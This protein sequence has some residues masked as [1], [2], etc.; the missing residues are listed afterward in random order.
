MPEGPEC[1]RIGEELARCVSSKNLVS[2]EFLSGRYTKKLPSGFDKFKESLPI[3]VVGVGVHGKFIYWILKKD[4]SLWNTLGMSGR[5]T[6]EH[7]DKHLHIQITYVISS[8]P[9]TH[10][11]VWFSDP[12][13]FGTLK[14]TSHL[15]LVE[16]KLRKLGPDLLS[17]EC[18]VSDLH[19]A[20]QKYPKKTLPAILMNQKLISGCGNYLKCESLYH[21]KLAPHREAGTLTLE[22][23]ECL[24]QSLTHLIRHSYECQGTTL[25]TYST[26]DGHVGSFVDHL[27]V[28]RKKV[29]SNGHPVEVL[30]STDGR[31]TYWVPSVQV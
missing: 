20:C 13:H 17:S 26:P 8:A 7:T 3:P 28:Y 15:S 29:D 11:H 23:I 5:W 27:Q 19:R 14:V 31:S 9:N 22:E 12:R 2:I 24:F 18:S 1:K 30:K 6:V 4:F 21:A 10:R 16:A 25:A